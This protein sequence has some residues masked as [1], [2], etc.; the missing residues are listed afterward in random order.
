MKP[1]FCSSFYFERTKKTQFKKRKKGAG[2]FNR[3]LGV[4][5]KEERNIGFAFM[6]K[7]KIL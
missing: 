3:K 2:S 4:Q 1:I 6:K 7:K 5:K